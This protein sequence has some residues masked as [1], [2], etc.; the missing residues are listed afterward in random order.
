M[1]TPQLVLDHH[2]LDTRHALLEVGALF[3]RF[4]AAIRRTGEKANDD[5]FRQLQ[6]AAM[7]LADP[8][9][10][11]RADKLLRLFSKESDE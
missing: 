1:Q 4:D 6:K 9:T 2:F 3:D 5:R 7:I 10:E 8:Q 11:N